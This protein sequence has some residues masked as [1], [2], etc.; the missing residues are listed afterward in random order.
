M[1]IRFKT[2]AGCF[3]ENLYNSNSY[4][5]TAI[6][7]EIEIERVMIRGRN[8]GKQRGV[9]LNSQTKA[10]CRLLFCALVLIS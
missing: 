4:R 8:K 9:R 7:I 6:E 5:A 1:F 10:N 2:T 3:S